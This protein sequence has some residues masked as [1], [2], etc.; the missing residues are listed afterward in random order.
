MRADFVKVDMIFSHL[1]ERRCLRD[2]ENMCAD[3][4]QTEPQKKNV[5]ES[6]IPD[7][8]QCCADFEV[9][10]SAWSG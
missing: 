3:L 2:L 5:S 7:E 8:Q 4:A 6:P 10:R 9:K 1:V